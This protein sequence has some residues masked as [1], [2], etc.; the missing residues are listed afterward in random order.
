MEKFLRDLT[1]PEIKAEAQKLDLDLSKCRDAKELLAQ[2]LRDHLETRSSD[3]PD[4]H[5][6]HVEIQNIGTKPKSVLNTEK[7]S[8]S[9]HLSSS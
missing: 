4:K 1:I 6:F 5:V 8:K 3:D 7:L 2:K 9:P